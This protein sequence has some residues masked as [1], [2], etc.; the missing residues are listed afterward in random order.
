MGKV[1]FNLLVI[2]IVTLLLI[3]N[4][5]AQGGIECAEF[6]G[7][8]DYL[9][10][11]NHYKF[12]DAFTVELWVFA[13]DWTPDVHQSLASCAQ[14]GGW[15]LYIANTN[16]INFAVWNGSSYTY[17]SCPTD[18]F[19]GY[20]HIAAT[21]NTTDFDLY[22]DGNHIVDGGGFADLNY[23]SDNYLIFG[24]EA[25]SGTVPTGNWFYGYIDEIRIWNKK[26]VESEIDEWMNKPIL[27]STLAT[28]S[29]TDRPAYHADLKGYY[30][31][32]ET[33]W[34]WL[35]DLSNN[36]TGNTEY[37]LT[38]H[39]NCT[40]TST[41]VPIGEFPENYTTDAKVLWQKFG[42]DWSEESDGFALKPHTGSVFETAEFYAIANNTASGTTSEDCPAGVSLRANQIWYIDDNS[43]EY[44]D[45]RFDCSNFA[46]SLIGA[47]ADV[48]NYK[49]LRRDGYFGDFS[50][51]QSANMLSGNELTFSQIEYLPTDGYYTIGV[52]ADEP[53]P[54]TLTN[55]A[56][57]IQGEFVNIFWTV[58]SEC[59]ISKYNLFR[60]E[61]GEAQLLIYSVDAENLSSI[62]TYEYHD[63][64]VES[65]TYTYWLESVE[66][67]GSFT[68]YDPCSITVVSEE[69]EEEEEED[70]DEEVST[71]LMGNY[72][73]PFTND[74]TIFFSL[75]TEAAEN[76]EIEIYN[77]RGQ[78]VKQYAVSNG[79]SSVF[80]SA[81]NK[82]AGVYIY[83]LVVDGKEVD[84]NRMILLK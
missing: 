55:F 57:V 32:N 49:L 13:W 59:G 6:D 50:I 70:I 19:S 76:I 83:K 25:G 31:F 77:M 43:N 41:N 71:K 11:G 45:F 33:D 66:D 40:Y 48:N 28:D 18:D 81:E 9:T 22:V 62:H 17:L 58:E 38:A 67:D 3:T 12:T 20:H 23:D 15:Y 52:L 47:S 56:S 61:N 16:K 54:V 10:P 39:G 74:T 2:L 75:S 35:D 64:E 8:G 42:S 63:Y 4:V 69:E 24:A 46:S 44:V 29:Y 82:A 30:R 80:W 14:N 68:V 51:I 7:N 78:L 5:Y 72:P 26:L 65:G 60:S 37:D 27:N 84:T 21:W 1:Y 73:N 36:V 79:Q 53:T 34:G